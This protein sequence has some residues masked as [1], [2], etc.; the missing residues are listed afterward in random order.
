M[1]EFVLKTHGVKFKKN[2]EEKKQ[3]HHYKI[4][5]LLCLEYQE[6]TYIDI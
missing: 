6:I 2:T 4:G 3:P 5:S 1:A